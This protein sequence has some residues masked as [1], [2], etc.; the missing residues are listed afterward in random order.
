MEEVQVKI[1]LKGR[2]VIGG[3]AEGE[4]VVTRQ[5]VSFLGGVN[6][7]K[8]IVVEKGHELEGQSLTGK[9]FIFPH[10][11]GSTAGPYI[12]YAM[13]KRKTAPAAMINVE[14]EP[15]IAVGAAMGNIPL[16]DRL[17]PNPLEAIATGDYVKIDGDQGIAEVIKKGGAEG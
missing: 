14:A 12:I 11:K 7:D 3:K 16:V 2:K 15:I 4:A 9:V 13:A 17:D 1:I 10:G 5:P 6:P 8:G